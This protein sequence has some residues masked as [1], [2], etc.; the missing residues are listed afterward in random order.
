VEWKPRGTSFWSSELRC[1]SLHPASASV[2][3]RVFTILQS[4]TCPSEAHS[5]EVEEAAEAASEVDEA[6]REAAHTAEALRHRLRGR[7][8]KTFSI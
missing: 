1:T 8:R 7:R 3:Q 6:A 4:T 5:E 2:H